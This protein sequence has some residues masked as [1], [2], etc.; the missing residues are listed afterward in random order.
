[1]IYLYCIMGVIW[2]MFLI[3]AIIALIAGAEDVLYGRIERVKYRYP[4]LGKRYD[5]K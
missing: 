5:K 1:M 3:C 2:W 4:Q